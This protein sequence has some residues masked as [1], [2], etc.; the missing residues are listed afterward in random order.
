M[1]WRAARYRAGA[2]RSPGHIW[3]DYDPAKEQAPSRVERA[4]SEIG[5]FHYLPMEIEVRQ[6]RRRKKT[7]ETKRR[8]LLP[9]YIFLPDPCDYAKVEGLTEILGFVRFGR[10]LITIREAEIERIRKAE[11]AI[12]AAAE[13][14]IEEITTDKTR[15][16]L[17]Q[18]LKGARGKIGEGHILAGQKI[19]VQ[20]MKGREY[21]EV[22]LLSLQQVVDVSRH[23]LDLEDDAA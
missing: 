14:R 8:A 18:K 17:E 2:T 10:E 6:H 9:G 1:I 20:A 13:L 3:Q 12:R 15:R 4:L 16:S 22:M 23:M 21:V 7:A 5:A 11:N 19:E